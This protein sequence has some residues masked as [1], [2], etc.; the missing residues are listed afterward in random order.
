YPCSRTNR[1][2]RPRPK[3]TNSSTAEA[4]HYGTKNRPSVPLW[5]ASLAECP[6]MGRFAPAQHVPHRLGTIRRRGAAP[7]GRPRPRPGSGPGPAASAGRLCP[8]DSLAPRP[9]GTAQ[10]LY[11]FAR[12]G[13]TG[14]RI[15]RPGLKNAGLQ[16]RLGGGPQTQETFHTSE[17]ATAWNGRLRDVGPGVCFSAKR[18]CG[19]RRLHA[20]RTVLAVARCAPPDAQCPVHTFWRA[21]HGALRTV[22]GARRPVHTSW[23]AAHGALRTVHGAR[24]PVHGARCPA[25]GAGP[26][27]R[28]G[29][30]VAG[31][32]RA[33][34]GGLVSWGR[35]TGTERPRT[36][37]TKSQRTGDEAK[38]TERK[39][40]NKSVNALAAGLVTVALLFVGLFV[41]LPGV[42]LPGK[43]GASA[44]GPVLRVV[45]STTVFADLA[46]NV[47]GDR[48]EVVSL[49]PANSDPHTWEPSTAEIRALAGA[50]VFLY[51]GLGLEPWADRLIANVGRSDLLVVRLSEGLQPREGVSFV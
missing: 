10:G 50:D 24:R 12:L 21:A 29:S 25:L 49:I 15:L 26:S 31:P 47:A 20:A 16:Q 18:L 46:A 1:Q 51:N 4:S 37:P 5:A 40:G 41:L 43:F 33:S 42:F 39:A 17:I 36:T 44:G 7:P 11:I 2:F 3:P 13:Y 34:L 23:R 32:D 27:H 8:W 45:T 22:H 38:M 9:T 6:T 48:A 19:P 30:A 35:A 14:R 28:E